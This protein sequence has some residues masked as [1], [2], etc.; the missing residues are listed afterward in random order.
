LVTGSTSGIGLA[1]ATALARRGADIV[2]NGFGAPSDMASLVADLAA[3]KGVRVVHVPADL[4]RP[5]MVAELVTGA[6]E[7]FG[8]VDI[9]V[10]NAGVF[11]TGAVESL[12]IDA[13][14]ATLSVNLTAAFLATRAVLPGMR[15]GGWGRVINIAS[16]LGLVG[17]TDASAYA[18]SKH[19]IVGLTRSVALETADAGITVNAICPGFVRTPLIEHEI[20]AAAARS[21]APRAEVLRDM[22]AHAQP[23]RRLIDPTEIGALAAFLCSPDACSVTGAAIAI[24][25]GW[26]AR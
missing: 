8:K 25:G 11:R 1:I 20:D 19:A 2:L 26:T 12:A 16:A 15:K 7:A 17:A 4:S 13:W 3:R 21:G 14:N 18:A 23:N 22:I 24:D 5:G 10:N 9:L 6:C